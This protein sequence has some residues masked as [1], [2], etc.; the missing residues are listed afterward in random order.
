V[1]R[2]NLEATKTL[3]TRKIPGA[4][5]ILAA[6]KIPEVTK[7]KDGG[8]ASVDYIKAYLNRSLPIYQGKYMI[9]NASFLGSICWYGGSDWEPL[10]IAV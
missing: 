6:R 7:L 9:N 8:G 3:V 10:R 2:K 5:I 1:D 4:I